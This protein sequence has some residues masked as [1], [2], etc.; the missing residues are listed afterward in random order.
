V[1]AAL[2]SMNFC[3]FF[4]VVEVGFSQLFPHMSMQKTGRLIEECWEQTSS[5]VRII[6][7]NTKLW[8]HLQ[9]KVHHSCL[10]I[11][12]V[13]GKQFLSF[14]HLYRNEKYSVTYISGSGVSI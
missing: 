3:S 2:V 9:T 13:L 5:S 7:R 8:D 4:E 10:W 14:V 6:L 1:M 12:T 11:Q